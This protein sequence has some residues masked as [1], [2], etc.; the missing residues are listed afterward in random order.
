MTLLFLTVVPRLR[1]QTPADPPL[2][3]VPTQILTAKR[4]FIS[5]VSGDFPVPAGTP[6]LTY[7]EFYSDRKRWGRFELVS[8]PA[9]SD[10][11][12]KIRFASSVSST[13]P[14]SR[15]SSQNL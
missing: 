6:D 5:N 7:D 1:A 4:V 3:P 12:F 11:V 15:L 14:I 13:D 8:A 10:L 9:D 2:A